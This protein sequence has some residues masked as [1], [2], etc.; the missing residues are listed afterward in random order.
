MDDRK[1]ERARDLTEQAVDRAIEGNTEKAR[2]LVEQAK[3][4]DPKTVEQIGEE[5]E[6]ERRE[7][8]GAADRDD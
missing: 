5:I 4:L 7:I 2:E 6:R 3:R 1:S 8:E